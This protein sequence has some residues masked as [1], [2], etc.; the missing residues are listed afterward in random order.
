[1]YDY[2]KTFFSKKSAEKFAMQLEA[3]GIAC[4]LVIER[5]YLNAGGR[6]YHIKW[7]G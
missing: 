4:I 3:Q 5:D 6:L 1:M 7:N 2:S